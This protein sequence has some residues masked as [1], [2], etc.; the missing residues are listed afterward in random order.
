MKKIAGTKNYKIAQAL[1]DEDYGE[2]GIKALRDEL[3]PLIR[4]ALSTLRPGSSITD[5]GSLPNQTLEM[6]IPAQGNMSA[7]KL[8]IDINIRDDLSGPSGIL[9]PSGYLDWNR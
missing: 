3:G 5:T 1:E 4:K 2:K 7:L 6:K 9:E 8:E